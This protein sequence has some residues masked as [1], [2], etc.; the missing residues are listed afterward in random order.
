MKES[1]YLEKYGVLKWQVRIRLYNF[2]EVFS[3]AYITSS[4]PELYMLR[5]IWSI[6]NSTYSSGYYVLGLGL[7]SHNN[8]LICI[9]PKLITIPVTY[10]LRLANQYF[11]PISV[12]LESV[13]DNRRCRLPREEHDT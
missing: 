10:I 7:L 2:I 4:F 3:Y 5:G 12:D 11:P 13:A 9:I 8:R 1:D 6:G